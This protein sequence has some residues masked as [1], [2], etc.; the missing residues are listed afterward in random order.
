V[1]SADGARTY[2]ALSAAV[3]PETLGLSGDDLPYILLAFAGLALTGILT[4]Q[5]ARTGGL[6]DDDR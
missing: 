4:R 6:K 1:A 5:L 2:P 3:A